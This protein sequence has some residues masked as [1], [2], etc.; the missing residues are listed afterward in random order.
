MPGA[1][2]SLAGA[3]ALCFALTGA[4]AA[5]AA[6]RVMSLDQCADQYVLALAPRGAIV[7][8]SPRVGD[9]DSFLG[10]QSAGLP[11]RRASSEAILAASPQVVVRYWGGDQKLADLLTRRRITVV[12][13]GEAADFEG[14]RANVRRVAAALGEPARGEALIARMDAQLAAARGAW[15][16]KSALYLTPSGFTAG[17]GTL[18]HAILAGAG[19]SDRAAPGY[20]PVSMERLV[21]DPPF[22]LVLGFFDAFGVAQQQWGPGRNGLLQAMARRRAIASLPASELGCPAWFAADAAQTLAQARKP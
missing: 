3:L 6:A 8:L 20:G 17:P 15:A 7:G 22:A 2:A 11:R 5:A 1:R 13:I 16:G 19:L 10:A 9:R 21:L 18:V 14:V 12:R 4:V